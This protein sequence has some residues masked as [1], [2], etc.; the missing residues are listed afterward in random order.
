MALLVSELG[1]C[2]LRKL[3]SVSVSNSVL[4]GGRCSI[5]I[6]DVL[7][8][9]MEIHGVVSGEF[10]KYHAS[11]VCVPGIFGTVIKKPCSNSLVDCNV[12]DFGVIF[13]SF[14]HF[15]SDHLFENS[16]LFVDLPLELVFGQPL[17]VDDQNGGHDVLFDSIYDFD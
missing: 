1:Q 7:G 4:S 3:K 2:C 14:G 16:H 9:Q 12:N 13:E 5:S 8:D 6:F 11:F 17:P 10:V 15:L